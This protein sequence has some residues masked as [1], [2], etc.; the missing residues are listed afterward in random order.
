LVNHLTQPTDDVIVHQIIHVQFTNDWLSSVFRSFDFTRLQT[1]M[2]ASGVLVFIVGSITVL[3]L[4][5]RF[6]VRAGLG[7]C[8]LF[9]VFALLYLF[10]VAIR[11]RGS[12]A[13][14]STYRF[15]CNTH[16]RKN[17]PASR[18]G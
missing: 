13:Q 10:L 5:I 1:A 7:I 11:G 3:L 14:N 18:G 12:W 4:L 17:L 15:G 16:P 8:M 9:S 6:T 2:D